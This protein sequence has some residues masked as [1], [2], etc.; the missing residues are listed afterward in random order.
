MIKGAFSMSK[1]HFRILIIISPVLALLAEI[2]EYIWPDEIL[3]N[4]LDYAEKVEPSIEGI[5]LIT[6]VTLLAIGIVLA[7]IVLF[8]L[9]MFKSWARPLYLAGFILMIPGYLFLGVTIH[10]GAGQLL[11]DLSSI[12]SGAIVVLIYYSPVT[13]FFKKT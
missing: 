9:L 10:S 5:K 7:L 13:T 11:L 4:I 2:Y 12:T 6:L 3:K 8:G 1:I